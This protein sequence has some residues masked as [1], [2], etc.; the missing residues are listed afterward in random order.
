VRRKSDDPAFIA[1]GSK[2]MMPG[3]LLSGGPFVTTK[4][5]KG[6]EYPPPGEEL[7]AWTV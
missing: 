4:E 7:T 6:L 3:I 2:E 1:F 5:I